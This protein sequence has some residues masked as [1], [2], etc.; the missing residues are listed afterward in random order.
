MDPF[1]ISVPQEDGSFKDYKIDP[2]FV[3]FPS[4][5]TGYRLEYLDPEEPY[6]V[7]LGTLTLDKDCKKMVIVNW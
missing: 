1:I 7:D 5:Q 6:P 4:K 2:I 3:M